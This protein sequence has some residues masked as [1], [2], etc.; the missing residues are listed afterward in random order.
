VS[1]GEKLVGDGP[2]RRQ[3]DRV[4]GSLRSLEAVALKPYA[5]STPLIHVII[6][7]LALLA[8]GIDACRRFYLLDGL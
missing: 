5:G 1:K 4:A 6:A 8:I 7:I 3:L 2:M